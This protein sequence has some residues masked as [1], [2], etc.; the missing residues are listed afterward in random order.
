MLATRIHM[1]RGTPYVY[2]GEEL[3]MTNAY[4]TRLDQYQ[5]VEVHNAWH[6]WVESGLVDGQDMMRYFARIARDNA[7]TPMQWNAEK[8]AGFTT[9]TPWLPVTGNYPIINAEAEAADPDSV[10]NYYRKLIALRH[11]HDIIVYGEFVP[12][13]EDHPTVYAYERRLDGKRL[14]VMLNWT[15]RT[16][17]AP[18]EEK[19][20]G[21]EL[22]S[23]YP[24]HQAGKLQPYEARVFLLK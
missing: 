7:R 14:T 2:Q 24:T 23:N 3:G 16:V 6:Q 15:D 12:L 10:Y 22:I 1:M 4:F 11:E 8:N 20:L 5:D 9:G 13:L 17:E 21:E 19:Q 18:L